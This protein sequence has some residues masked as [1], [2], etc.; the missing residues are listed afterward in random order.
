MKALAIVAF[1]LM[2]LAHP[3]AAAAVLGAELAI[4]G[5]LGGLVWR[6][7]RRHPHPYWRTA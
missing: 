2:V 5:V 3:A 1:V 6:T 4:C 7:V